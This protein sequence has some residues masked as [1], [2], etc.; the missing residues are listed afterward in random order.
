MGQNPLVNELI[1]AGARFLEEFEKR[2][3]VAVAFWLKGRDESSWNLHIASEKI[4]DAKI[5]EAYGEVHRIPAQ[6][7]DVYFDPFD[8]ILRQMDDPIVQYALDSQRRFPARLAT[9][10][11]VPTFEGVEVEGMYLYPP[12][13]T[14]GV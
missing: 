11:N 8:V 1:E 9:V 5:R 14:A 2:Y 4:S 10:F 13:H 7:K 3:P 12:G 6:L